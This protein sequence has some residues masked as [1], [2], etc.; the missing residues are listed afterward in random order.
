MTKYNYQPAYSA[1]LKPSNGGEVLANAALVNKPEYGDVLFGKLTQHQEQKLHY[2]M[3]KYWSLCWTSILL[4][5]LGCLPLFFTCLLVGYSCLNHIVVGHDN[6]HLRGKMP[7]HLRMVG[8]GLFCS[9]Y[10]PFACTYGDNEHEHIKAHHLTKGPL[11]RSEKDLDTLWSDQPLWKMLLHFFVD[12]AHTSAYDIIFHQYATHP[13][14]IWPERIAANICHWAQLYLLYQTGI[15]WTILFTGHCSM[16]LIWTAF[17][18]LIHRPDFYKFLLDSDPSGG[19]RIHPILETIAR[20]ISEPAWIE[21]KWHD[22]HHTHGH[23]LL[24]FGAQE[25]RGVTFDEIEAALADLVDEGLFVDSDGNGVSPLG[26]AGH[27]VGSRKQFLKLN[28][29]KKIERSTVASQ[30]LHSNKRIHL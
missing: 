3:L 22:V 5:Y 2:R 30:K 14:D 16:F 24:S 10:M 29:S 1:K 4:N 20:L 15:F 17:H 23:S 19:R 25:I 7:M 6:F 28:K 27:K 21:M 26:E 11:D 18:G 12:P 13:A 8:F 9:G